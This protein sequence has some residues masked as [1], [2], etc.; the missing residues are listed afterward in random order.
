MTPDLYRRAQEIFASAVT[1]SAESRAGYLDG[2]CG[3][4]PELRREVESLLASHEVASEGFL[5]RPAIEE[6]ESVVAVPSGRKPLPRGSRLGGFEIVGPLGAGGMGEV[7][8]ARD[9]RL[10]RDVAIKVLPIDV[11]SDRERLKRFEK[12]ARSASALNHP[13]IVTIYETGTSDGLPWIAMEHVEGETLRTQV[14]AGPLQTKR[15]LNIAVQIAEGLARAHEAG[16]VHRDLKPE[17][18]MVTKDGLVKILDFGLAKLQGPVSGGS[19]QESQL[20]TVT[21]TSPGIVL[22]TVGY[23]SP[24]QASGKPVDFRSDQFSFGSILYEMA[25]GRRAFQK[26][27]AVETLTAILNEEPDPIAK[28]APQTP[29]PLRW[30][31]ERCLSKEPPD[32]YASTTDLARE[33][34]SL[35]GHLSEASGIAT[36][37]PVARRGVSSRLAVAIGLAAVALLSSGYLVARL[38]SR[39]VGQLRFQKV[40]FQR[41]TIMRARFAPDGQTVVYGMV[42][43][44][45]DLKPTELFLTRAGSL[46]ARSLGLPP[47][48]ILSVS[49]SGQ[50]AISLHLPGPPSFIGTLA[51]VSLSGGAPRQLLEHVGGADWSPDGRELAVTRVLD[52]KGQLELPIGKV[53][54]R[55][56]EAVYSPRVSP[57]GTT[58]AFFEHD[59]VKPERLRLVDR[60]GHVRTL[61]EAGFGGHLAWSPHGDEV[62]WSKNKV[63]TISESTEV[64]AVDLS[65]QDRVVATLGG[66]LFLHDLSRDGRLLLE[67]NDESYDMVATFPGQPERNLEWLDQSVPIALSADNR[68]LLFDDRGDPAGTITAAYIRGTDGSPAVR[69]GEGMALDLSPDGKWALVGR[70]GDGSDRLVLLPT[71]AGQETV[72]ATGALIFSRFENWAAFGPAGK[73]ILFSAAEPGHRPRVYQQHIKGGAPRAVSAEGVLPCLISRDG[74]SLLA[75]IEGSD[76]IGVMAIGGTESKPP[77]IVAQLSQTS[78]PIHWSADGESVL[79]REAGTRPDRVDRLDL[80]TGERKPWRSFSAAGRT[81]T[82][83]LEALVVTTNEDGW[84]AAYHR[85]FSQLVVVDGLK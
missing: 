12:E 50:L 79:I 41:G 31:V 13:N 33:L 4:D 9:P 43:V 47:A 76:E 52:D 73:S 8:K 34:A 29:A 58:V 27:T 69:L 17:N 2:A 83:G 85:A 10:G 75:R 42:A 82:G 23:M 3:N 54:Y 37:D 21:G 28:L 64:H 62:W 25:T 67:K 6:M 63:G 55:G 48:D 59:P 81:G 5:E 57:D 60:K 71:G 35:R 56:A 18:V 19:D 80:A 22:G 66:D 20:P 70:Q 74:A 65:G 11:A 84:V 39:P 68:T 45:D 72:L 49:S 44:G 7:Y 46:D 53:L 36:I 16:I 78:T 15:L 38:H 40:T 61:S 77:R 32:R 26:K 30:I 24:E 1:R 51:E 14:A